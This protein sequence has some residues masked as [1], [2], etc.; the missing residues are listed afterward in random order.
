MPELPEVETIVRDL[1][2]S[3]VGQT[4]SKVH[5]ITRT[6]WY[7]KPPVQSKLIAGIFAI[8]RR[9]KNILI[10]LSNGHTLA[11]HLKMTGRLT[12]EYPHSELKK[13]THFTMDLTNGMQVRFNDIRRFGYLDLFR[14]TELEKRP[15]IQIL[16]PDALEI[17]KDDFNRILRGKNR[18]IKSL[19]LDQSIIAGLG[20][21]YSDEAL[22]YARVNPRSVSS[23]LSKLKIFHLYDSIIDVLNRAIESRGSSIDDYVDAQGVKGNFQDSHKVYG[24]EGESCPV[25]GYAIIREV[26][27]S[28]SAHYCPRCQR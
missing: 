14:E 6:V 11:I 1:R 15:Y 22:F 19:L 4:I 28:R 10:S 9:G 26:I 25:C 23:K 20:N 13:H 24:R 3:L 12:I 21:I 16:G 17:S 18:I 7:R 5:F 2:E 8:N 27:G